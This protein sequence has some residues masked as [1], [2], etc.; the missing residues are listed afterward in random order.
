MKAPGSPEHYLTTVSSPKQIHDHPLNDSPAKMLYS[1]PQ[2]DRFPKRNLTSSCGQAFYDINGNLYRSQRACSLGKGNKFDF[3][4]TA[5]NVPASNTYCP[6]NL[7]I[8][9]EKHKGFSFGMSREAAPQNGIL[10]LLKASGSNPGP[11]AYMPMPAKSQK[12]VTFKIK[13]RQHQKENQDVGP[14]KYNLPTFFDPVKRIFDSKYQSAKNIRFAPAHVL[15]HNKQDI[16]Q[17]KGFGANSKQVFGSDLATDNKY[18]IN[19]VGRFFNSKYH[20]SRCRSFGKA[21]RDSRGQL[22]GTPGP[23]AYVLPSEFGIYQSS[24][25]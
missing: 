12:S 9:A 21:L 5:K 17:V 15:V 23:G 4:K 8:G 24:H 22:Y 18:Q 14:G 13:I 11:G 19:P 20:D 3:A 2:A 7:T 1:F 10:P 25:N 6:T 16:E